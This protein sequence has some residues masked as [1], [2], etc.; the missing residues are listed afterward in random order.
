MILKYHL[1]LSCE[2][3]S[4]SGQKI[5]DVLNKNIEQ[6]RQTGNNDKRIIECVCRYNND[7]NQLKSDLDDLEKSFLYV[8][9][10]H[11]EW[12]T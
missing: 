3:I 1:F 12:I 9:N 11:E 4:V 10:T 8:V 2:D 6:H 5:E 7:I